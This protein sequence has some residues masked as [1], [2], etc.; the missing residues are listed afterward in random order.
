M[1]IVADKAEQ[2]DLQLV[3]E[4]A[5]GLAEREPSLIA[6]GWV[7]PPY[8][9]SDTLFEIA[10][11]PTGQLRSRR[12]IGTAF[13]YAVGAGRLADGIV[14]T[15]GL[16]ES[17]SN[18]LG[19]E[20][21]FVEQ[22]ADL[23]MSGA[24]IA[25]LAELPN[26]VFWRG[27]PDPALT[28]LIDC[29]VSE[30]RVQPSHVILTP[31]LDSGGAELVVLW[32]ARAVDALGQTALVLATDGPNDGW[33]SRLPNSAQFIN[34]PKLLQREQLVG[35][36]SAVDQAAALAVALSSLPIERLHVVNSYIGFQLLRFDFGPRDRKHFVSLFGIGRDKYGLEAGYWCEARNLLGS[37]T[38]LTDNQTLPNA[39]AQSFGLDPPSICAISYP[40][41]VLPKGGGA[42]VAEEGCVCPKRVLWAS[43]LDA[44]KLPNLV[45]E[46]ARLLPD[47]EFHMFGRAVL[48]DCLLGAPPA[49]VHVRGAFDGWATL[50]LEPF[51]CFLFTSRW[52]GLPNIILEAMA[53]QL[54]IVA[55]CVGAIPE[56]LTP[57]RGWLVTEVFEPGAYATAVREALDDPSQAKQ[58]AALAFSH[59][60]ERRSFDNFVQQLRVVGYL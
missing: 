60:S 41:E 40:V 8:A 2:S 54:P 11:E 32:H 39:R 1:P 37:P 33:A 16:I 22:I 50:P 29:L 45:F 38:F 47:I 15:Q 31:W 13:P 53:A 44:E 6:E 30:I 21:C 7:E 9:W 57:E 27:E 59:I 14:P 10:H 49:N 20:A 24:P 46:I 56:I 4:W 25:A 42:L 12:L 58:R 43:R 28:R 26:N 48:N 5:L 35:R 34:L 36:L 51:D 55:S 23:A 19:I 17:F 52:E 3:E 18:R